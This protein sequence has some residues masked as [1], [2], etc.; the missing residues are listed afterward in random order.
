[1]NRRP[2]PLVVIGVRASRSLSAATLA[3]LTLAACG[4]STVYKS[5]G[6]S[7][8]TTTSTSSAAS[9]NEIGVASS[10]RFG[11]FLI[12]GGG[13]TLYHFDG[14]VGATIACTSSCASVWPPLLLPAGA[15]RP[16]ST[17][18]LTGL[19]AVTR[20]DGGRQ[21]TYQGRPLYRYSR[22]AKRGDTNG[23]GVGGVWHV[24]TVTAAATTTTAVPAATATRATRAPTTTRAV[25]QTTAHTTQ[26]TSAPPTSPPATSPPTTSPSPPPP[27]PPP[28][29]TTVCTYPPC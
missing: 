13:H 24:A 29:P 17:G 5:A 21:V 1:M 23:E 6:E 8:H 19:S 9:A 20:P 10:A 12:D 2:G 3:L 28:P 4:K 26:T 16:T 25:T 18:S 22:D 27:P 14:D 11:Q 7:A 15:D